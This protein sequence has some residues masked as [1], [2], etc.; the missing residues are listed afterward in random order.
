[1]KKV[2]AIVFT[3]LVAHGVVAED[4]M[5]LSDYY[6]PAFS[7][8]GTVLTGQALRD[9]LHDIID[10][11]QRFRYTHRT[12]RDV[13]DAL[14]ELDRDPSN[15][16]NVI[17]IYTGRSHPAVDRDGTDGS[18]GDSWNREHT[19][20]SSLGFGSDSWVPYTD[21]HA[22]RAADRS[23]N[24]DRSN[25]D[26]DYGGDAH[27]EASDARFDAD[28]WEP[29]NEVKGDIARGLLYMAIRYEGDVV[30]E[31]DLEI[32]EDPSITDSS[33]DGI[34]TIAS[35]SALLQWH[36]DDPPDDRERLRNER[37]YTNWQG[38]RN[39]FVDHPEWAALI[40]WN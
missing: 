31:P 39:P 17:L 23:T 27:D 15:P 32:V 26:Y 20:P 29:P 14:I 33:S 28:S 21:L 36:E 5:S 25:L 35:L 37:I 10:D 38:N 16:D 3:V 2:I 18:D 4:T 12:E 7:S 13:W 24:T 30:G 1:M 22:L 34:G 11:H 40:N 8:G 9:A 19:W 6:A